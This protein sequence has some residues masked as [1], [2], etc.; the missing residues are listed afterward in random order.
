ML[1]VES[2]GHQR[3]ESSTDSF[4]CV[5]EETG[6]D[7]ERPPSLRGIDSDSWE[8]VG[9]ESGGCSRDSRTRLSEIGE[10]EAIKGPGLEGLENVELGTEKETK[11]SD[12]KEDVDSN[13]SD[14]EK[15]DD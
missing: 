3:S 4:V 9:S 12:S 6:L 11:E 7:G 10:E 5:S 2:S 8:Q 14:W 15:W 1:K 13:T